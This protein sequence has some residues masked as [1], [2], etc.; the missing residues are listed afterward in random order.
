M[1]NVGAKHVS[2]LGSDVIGVAVVSALATLVL[3]VVS[4]LQADPNVLF[5]GLGIAVPMST[6]AGALFILQA[7]LALI[8]S[9]L[10]G[11][12]IRR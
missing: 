9:S 1:Y 11:I 8:G 10:R 7:V 2:V 3:F 12:S 4:F 6:I 5:P